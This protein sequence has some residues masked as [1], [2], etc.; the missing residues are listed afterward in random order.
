MARRDVHNQIDA[1]QPTH[2]VI[3]VGAGPAGAGA[4]ITLA[5]RG[6]SVLLVD[7]ASFPRDKC[8]GDG[9][10][11]GAL[12]RLEELGL[13]PSTIPSWRTVQDIVVR[14]PRARAVTFPL[15]RG[16]GVFA[17]VA[18]RAELDNALVDL[19][20]AAGAEVAT[21]QAV[22]GATEDHDGVTVTIEELGIVRA[23]Y[24]IG[25]DGMWSP[26]RR[27]LGARLEG[28]RGDWHAFRQYLVDVSE[29]ATRELMIWFD[30]DLLPGYAW[31]FPLAEGRVNFGFG[32]LRG[33]NL[34]GN[35][36]NRRWEDLLDRPHIRS[37]LGP[38]AR[39]DG[40][41]KAW[42]IPTRLPGPELTTGRGIFVGDAAALGDP[43]TGEGIGQALASGIAAADAVT[44]H[45]SDPT[46]AVTAYVDWV[47]HELAPD[48]RMADLLSRALAHRKGARA[49]IA[50]AGATAWTRRNF[51]RWLFED[52]P[53]G[54]LFTPSRLHPRFLRRDGAF[55]DWAEGD[56]TRSTQS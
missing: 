55:A 10:T 14:G 37:F 5:R 22:T 48:T 19:A 47:D 40:P 27:F 53:R 2:D 29:R 46:N 8:C 25:A 15:P 12:R 51:A 49:A 34:D 4:A 7:K 20:R 50:T 39:P 11:T 3:V 45:P 33:P 28:Y 23:P 44:A 17:A 35:W 36:M 26:M 30:A 41:R 6:R 32:V 9:L 56:R 43:M 1:P 21:G 38:D 31:S 54:V 16:R 52:E 18:R 24:V 42:P 13:D